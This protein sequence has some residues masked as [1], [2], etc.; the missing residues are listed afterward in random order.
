MRSLR[1]NTVEN[2]FTVALWNAREFH[3]HAN[4]ARE[5]SYTKR[6]W[7]RRRLEE[8][9]PDACFLLEVMGGLEA[10]TAEMDGLRAWAHQIGYVVR[11][12]IGEG[13]SN[14]EKKQSEESYTNGIAVLVN[15]ATCFI[16]R[17]SRIEERVMGVWLRGRNG[18][19][20]VHM[21]VAALHGLHHEGSS[22][23]RKQLQ[24]IGE[25]AVDT[26]QGVKGCLIVGDFNYVA[27][28][29]W[30]SSH[31]GLSAN[32]VCFKNLLAQP[33]TGYVGPVADKPLIVWTRKGGEAAEEGCADG[34]GSMLDGAITMGCECG[35]WQRAIVEFAFEHGTPTNGTAAKPL[36]DHAWLTFSRQVP[37]LE[38]RGEKRP[39]PALP[40]SDEK[41]KAA[42]RDRVRQGDI[43]EEVCASQNMCGGQATTRATRL[44]QEAAAQVTTELRRRRAEKPLETAHRWRTW[45]QEAYAARHAGLSPHEMS[46]GLF[47]WHSR[48]WLIRERYIAAGDDVCWAKIV[49]RC[50]RNWTRANQRLRRKQQREDARL[51]ELSLNIVEGKGSR[52]LARMAMQAWN[53]IRPLR[54]SLAFDRFHPGDDVSKTAVTAVENPDA[55]LKGLAA[56]GERLV[57]GFASTP[58]I[59][60]AFTA[61]CSVFCPTFETL[62]GRDGGEWKLA[63]ELTFPVF[64]QV[65]KRVPRGK[66]VGHGG[67]SI[68]LLLHADRCVQKAFYECLMADLRG[69]VF[70]ESWRRVIYVLLTKPLPSNPALISERREIALMAQDMK[71]IMHMV[72]ATAYRLITGRLLPEQCGW[73][74]GYGTVDAGLP[75]AAVI[76]QAQRLRQSIWILYVDLA[77]L[78]RTKIHC[79]ISIATT[80][81]SEANI[82]NLLL[83][84]LGEN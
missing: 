29:G 75:L 73:L 58:P 53:A 33:D 72:R 11:W 47:N 23:F 4:P 59:L 78:T 52:D 69:E 16:E 22:S 70:P 81:D 36:S 54:A 66:A 1:G 74:P 5:A 67:F 79:L 24:A 35:F 45:L 46:G 13:G 60:D 31:A 49:A 77:T 27:H 37:I 64:L 63:K 10:F 18:K 42:F 8:E 34:A 51:K 3:A 2:R 40:R 83:I 21:R 76:Q 55:F 15:Q 44:L 57:Q 41:A 38:L 48:L 14:R 20:Q 28:E 65:L 71:L 19:A 32:D 80:L 68:E 12:I 25:W 39:L 7:L 9:R 84:I 26:A 56:E 6:Q 30:R 43:Q 62:R 82:K 17:Y 50:R 61:F